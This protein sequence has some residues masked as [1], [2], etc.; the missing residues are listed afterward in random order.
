MNINDWSEE[1]KKSL[2]N[3]LQWN[4]YRSECHRFFYVATPKVACTTLKWWVAA[5]EGYA[6]ELRN[7]T[8]SAES[9]RDLVVHESHRV[10]PN[11]TGLKLTDLSEALASDAYFRFAVVRNPYKRI[12]SAWQ[13]K[14]ML[15]EP[16]QSAPYVQE[17]F[18]NHPV[19]TISD[20]AM[21]FECFLEHLAENEAP[22]FWDHHWTPQAKLLRPDLINYSCVAKIE[23]RETLT[24]AL[25]EW[26][27]FYIPSPFQGRRANESLIPYVSDFIT[28]RSAE[29]IRTLYA[30][31]FDVFGY[32]KQPPEAKDAFSAD[33][34]DIAIK[35]IKLIRGRH[36]R[37]GERNERITVLGQNLA[38]RDAQVSGLNQA[39][40]V[41][42]GQISGLNQTLAERDA[43]ISEREQEFAARDGQISGLQQAFAAQIAG[44]SQ[45]F[46]VRDGQISG[47]SQTLAERDAQI[48][49][50]DQEL[51]ARDGQISGL[52]QAFAAQIAGFSQE[53]AA[54]DGQIAGLNQTLEERDAQISGLDQALAARDGQIAGLSQTLA[55][56]DAQISGLDQELAARD[57]QIGRFEQTLAG[58]DAQISYQE[59]RIQA[60]LQSHSWRCTQPLRLISSHVGAGTR[61][62][63]AILSRR[64]ARIPLLR[65]FAIRRVRLS[66]LFDQAF[67]AEQNPDVGAAGIDPATHYCLSG[68]KEHRDPSALF[69]TRRY[70]E[71]H[72]DVAAAHINPLLHYIEHGQAEGRPIHRAADEP[73]RAF[74]AGGAGQ[75]SGSVVLVAPSV[76][77]LDDK[78]MAPAEAPLQAGEPVVVDPRRIDEEVQAI[79]QSGMFD[80]AYYLAMY[81]DIQPSPADPIRHYCERGWRE[82]RNPSD[83]FDTRGYLDAYRD[84][85][86]AALNPFWHYVVAGA[87][88]SRQATPD[89][90]SRYEDDV[91]FGQLNSDIQLVAYY[92]RP[93]WLGVQQA[94]KAAKGVGKMLMPHED[95][96]FYAASS[97]D[98]LAKQALMARRHGVSAWCFALDASQKPAQENPLGVF[99]ASR[100]LGMKFMLDIDL[101]SSRVDELF[102]A[103]LK[104]ALADERYLRMD[105]RPALVM[106]LPDDEHDCVAALATFDALLKRDR[107]PRPYRVGRRDGLSERMSVA[108]SGI[109]LDAILDFPVSPVP[110]ETGNFTPL[111]K[112]GI[113][114][115]PYSVIVSQAI[116][117]MGA[118]DEYAIPCYRSVTLGRDDAP[119][120]PDVTLRYSRYNQKECRRWLDAAIADAR[121]RHAPG[122]RLMFVN[123]WNDWSRGAVLEPDR[124]AGY[125]KLNEISRALL[126]L[127][128]GLPLPKVSVIV[129]NY[130]HAAYLRRRLDSIYQ[131]TYTNIEVLLLDDCSTD[132]SRDVLTEYADRY[133]DVTTQLFN[134]Q[135]S[136]SVFRQWAKGIKAATGDLIWI[137]ESDDYCDPD[138]LA[139]LVRCFDDEAVMLA[140]SKTEFVR[141]DESVMPDE[142]MHHVRDLACRDKWAHSYVNTAHR[143]VSEALGI[144]NT[145]PNAS[146][147][148][149]RRPVDMPLLDD[150]AWLSMRVVGDWIFYLHQ[151]RGGKLAYSAETTNYFRRYEG[152]T[153]A[154]TYKKEA[155]YRELNVA[156]RA[157][158]S[159]YDVPCSVIEKFRKKVREYYD[160]H[161]GKSDDEFMAWCDEGAILDARR[162]RTP[163]IAV[164][165][166]GFYPGG[167]EILPIRMANEF[168]R[169]GYSVVLLSAG[170][171]QREDGV[172]RMLRKD[173]PLI[174][175][176][177][178]EATKHLV[179]EFGIEVLNSHQWH[180]Q[181]YPIY[182]SDVFSELKAHVA[183][184]HGMIEHGDAF[185]VTAEQ[186][187]IAHENVTTWAY[188]ADKNL[189]PFIEHG[190]YEENSLK[191]MKLPNG[192][193]PPVIKPVL[194]AE[195][196][197]PEDAF[198]LCCVSRAIPDKGWAE[199][200]EAV[201]L[202]RDVSGK[203][204]RL[205]LVGNG[206]VY[207]EY[208]GSGGVP[209]FV[210]LAGF[211]ENS[212]GFYSAADMG[213]M[214]TKFKSESFPLTIVDCL[215]A[216]RPYIAT[217]VGEIRNMLDTGC[218]LAGEVIELDDWEVP[219]AQ[220][221]QVIASYATDADAL[222]RANEKVAEAANRYRIDVVARQYI[223]IIERTIKAAHEPN[224]AVQH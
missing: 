131:Q 60:L 120:K 25:V 186:L 179:N 42:D 198:V 219:V 168:K 38:E 189:G 83:D 7:V 23:E 24:Q 78:G 166:M 70:L 122:Q 103:L 40:A 74:C 9:D 82:G 196:G 31:D 149:F 56:R 164:S 14:L 77:Q 94:R 151:L 6:E 121:A 203:D 137:A 53:I 98:T 140:Y 4:S 146:G 223:S 110:G 188:T 90:N 47:L 34:F 114:S 184:L 2:G 211:S 165:T 172:R 17:E 215:F 45:E 205:I 44:F 130:N 93:D 22:S 11:V 163:C 30:H 102:A 115:V 55:E 89:S 84:I 161:G 112:N 174:E 57:G 139:K 169:Q 202:A 27:G 96:G 106:T 52:Q 206:P 126:G 217:A 116:A 183:S 192:M 100:E 150:E 3:Y 123:A 79:A 132:Q 175:T 195:I 72:P 216:G 201:T 136:G 35:A 181:K 66:P 138:F 65:Q 127:P 63:R 162:S 101:R 68:W 113:V 182:V 19:R 104:R 135:N 107:I 69:S 129:P 12:F 111:H 193:Q 152:S 18:F 109:E 154:N 117:R 214:L 143:E 213:I 187:K 178:I 222:R 58:R 28:V 199:M 105:G 158:Q 108:A 26:L 155:F 33:Q 207:D 145:I 144:I 204:I 95:L 171:G 185:G 20:V 41:R 159:L 147:A 37:L 29:L 200:I 92:T 118:R 176:P 5:M 71:L 86:N 156:A 177:D 16:L 97:S 8:D 180:V 32:D 218:G 39:L 64:L 76:E 21:A 36:Q 88:E 73:Q 10:A 61:P 59:Q 1:D 62:V 13:S 15:Q 80:V 197:M 43:Q 141:A 224:E 54:R 142:F 157:V 221:A 133:P 134:H 160:W 194:R 85:K 87:S 125:S 153:A 212:V 51:A 167:A 208:C 48:S 46:A 209:A 170:H 173:I 148:V 81:P 124:L 210:Y 119:L 220:A 191:F 190:L 50:L 67:Y 49:G 99:L 91:Y 128:S 75:A